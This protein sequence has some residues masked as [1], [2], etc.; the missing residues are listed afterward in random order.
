[1]A[2]YPGFT[3]V[4]N[5]KSYYIKEIHDFHNLT[6]QINNYTTGVSF[7]NC[8][9]ITGNNSDSIDGLIWTTDGKKYGLIQLHMN[10]DWI[11]QYY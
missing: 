10:I 11:L 8:A 3:E 7:F 2:I 4:C 5:I 9:L 1:M 6:Y